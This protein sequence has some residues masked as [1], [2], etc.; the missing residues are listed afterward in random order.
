MNMKYPFI[1][2]ALRSTLIGLYLWLV[3]W[4][5]IWGLWPFYICRLFNAKFIFIQI[6][7]SISNNSVEYSSFVKTFLF[8]AIL[9]SQAVLIQT[10][11][12]SISII[13][14]YTVKCQNSSISNNSVFHKCTL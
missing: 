1:V 14:V 8:Q 2:I 10:I 7:S 11:Q 13:F 6:I 3:G 5:V 9:L 12:F 4:L